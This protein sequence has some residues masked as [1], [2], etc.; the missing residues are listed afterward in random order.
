MSKLVSLLTYVS[1]NNAFYKGVMATQGITDALDISQYPIFSR[2]QLQENRYKMFSNG[3]LAKYN[4][5]A[6]RRH[7][8]SGSSGIPVNVYWDYPDYHRS[9]LTLWRRRAQYYGIRPNDKSVNIEFTT[10]DSTLGSEKILYKPNEHMMQIAA[11]QLLTES[12]IIK[13]MDAIDDFAPTWICAQPSALR[14]L[15]NGYKK[16][17]RSASKGLRYIEMVGEALTPDIQTQ[18]QQFFGV[19]VV[20]LYASQEVNGIAYECPHHRLHVLDDNVLVECLTPKGIA[21]TG[22]GE[23][24]ITSLHNKAMP[25]IR[26]NQGDM[27]TLLGVDGEQCVCGCTAQVIESIHGRAR[28]YLLL[29]GVEIGTDLL[30]RLIA[31]VNNEYDDPILEYS[32]VYAVGKN[33]IT[34]T[35][36]IDNTRKHWGT[37]V[38]EALTNTFYA[39]VPN[40]VSFSV[41]MSDVYQATSAKHKVWEVRD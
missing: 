16:C 18:S 2:K 29:G 39:R 32:F 6:L 28:D 30:G 11:S 25:I 24:I 1:A 19:P 5:M 12:N 13:A 22:Y 33:K 34:C 15:I 26:Y 36:A 41:V 3:Y 21:T 37:K 17:N 38:A 27:I 40:I 7:S 35:I 9:M 20:N 8:T 23:A 31:D 10:L 14:K 4:T